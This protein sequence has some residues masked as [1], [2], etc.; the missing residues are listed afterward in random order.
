M[1]LSKIR[2]ALERNLN[3]TFKRTTHGELN[4]NYSVEGNNDLLNPK[5]KQNDNSP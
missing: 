4:D 5:G 3:I 1:I 2:S